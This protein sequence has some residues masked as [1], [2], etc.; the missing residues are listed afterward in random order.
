L[1]QVC[2]ANDDGA[3]LGAKV[4]PRQRQLGVVGQ[5]AWGLDANVNNTKLCY[6][7]VSMDGAKPWVHFLKS[8]R[9]GHI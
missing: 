3:K 9:Q 5:V 4:L 2:G 6:L 1:Y 8:F 7:G